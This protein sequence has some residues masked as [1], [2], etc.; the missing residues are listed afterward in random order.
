MN[1]LVTGGAG[2]IGCHT[3]RALQENGDTPV[4]LDNLETGH[5]RL[6][7]DA[8]LIEG[9]VRDTELVKETI[10][11]HRIEAVIHFAAHSLVG[12]SMVKPEMYLRDNV[13]MAV[14]VCHAMA[15]TGCRTIVLSSSAAVYGT[16]ARVPI[17]EDDPLVPTNPYGQSK[18]FM[19]QAVNW[20][21][22][23]Y[24]I[25]A[26][27]LRYFNAA[28]AHPKG[29][30]KELHDPETHLV[31][32]ALQAVSDPDFTL[33]LYG[34]DYPTPDGTCIRDY[35]HVCDL[36]TAH[37]LALKALERD[38]KGFVCNLGIGQGFSVRQVIRAVEKVTGRPVKYRECDRRPGDPPVLVAKAV[39]A[40]LLLGWEPKYRDLEGIVG[41]AWRAEMN[42]ADASG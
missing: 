1:V 42:K 6:A 13:D 3:V 5:R 37:L 11:K 34:T 4:V 28:G 19:E 29:D 22:R 7:K 40:G 35:I 30:L 39:R 27:C 16:P 15:Q 10:A 2:Y 32:L 23:I 38:N 12:E 36:A 24:G 41:S 31:P 8:E 20:Y 21:E 25:R 18:V 9:D 33:S 17:T 26:A 14:A